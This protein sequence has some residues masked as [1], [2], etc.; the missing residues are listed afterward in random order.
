MQLSDLTIRAARDDDA[1]GLIQ[2]IEGCFHEYE[3][4]VMDL[5]GVD[6]ELKAI[7]TY[8]EASGGA[9]WVVL[10]GSKIAASVGYICHGENMFGLIRLYVDKNYR[11]MGL[12]TKLLS[13]VT[14]AAKLRGAK[15]DMWS[16]RRFVDSHAFYVQHGYVKQVETRDLNDPSNTVEFHFIEK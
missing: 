8:V 3:G 12:A 4:V 7:K 10:D 9:F 1:E 16:D 11:R 5:E 14:D 15:L 13:L 2:M 6:G